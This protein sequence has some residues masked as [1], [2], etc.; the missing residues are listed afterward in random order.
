MILGGLAAIL[1]AS[2]GRAASEIVVSYGGFER[3]LAI[4]DLEHFSQ[5]GELSPQLQAYIWQLQWSQDSLNQIR[6]VLVTPVRNPDVVAVSQFL[7]TE[8]GQILLQQITRAVQA[9]VRQASFSALRAALIL[10][11]ASHS[12]DLTFLDVLRAYPLA[13]IRVDLVGVLTIVQE[14][15]QAILQSGQAVARVEAI[16]K[17]QAEANPLPAGMFRS[18]QQMVQADHRYRVKQHDLAVPGVSKPATLFL[19]QPRPGVRA[20]SAGFPVI[21][22]SHGLGGSRR[23]YSYLAQ[24]L[25]A[26][27]LAVVNL[28]HSGSN[29]QQLINLL[30]GE[31]DSLVPPIEFLRRPEDVS[32]TITALTKARLTQP[33]LLGHLNM[34][35]VGVIGQSLGGYT[36]LALAG[37]SF[38]QAKLAQYCPASQ[39]TFNPSLL[40]Q[41]QAAYLG[42]PNPSLADPRVKAIFTISSIGSALFGRSGYGRISIPTMMVAGALDTVAPA[43]PEQ[44]QPFSWLTTPHRYLLLMHKGTHFSGIGD[45]ET[46]GSDQ[47]LAIPS[48]IIGSRPDLAQN[49]IKIFA[50]AFFKL[51]LNGDERFRPLLQPS[52]AWQLGEASFP[53]SLTPTLPPDRN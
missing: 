5:T 3:S 40:L 36:A 12:D 13:T 39:V 10:A 6:Q 22:I 19:P 46:G 42:S 9:P 32:L 43:F 7:Y 23:S 35:Q 17:Q 48:D 44:I 18:L 47:A 34:E 45:G 53:L 26:T 27:G 8:Q 52:F 14:V 2:P 28:E 21:I 38:D 11:A 15:N 33:A 24:D 50:Q 4:A 37:A 29:G 31:T 16:A 41:C 30:R 25:A 51:T 1:T 49:Y 20:P